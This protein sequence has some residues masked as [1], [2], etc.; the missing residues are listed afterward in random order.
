MTIGE[1]KPEIH[2]YLLL[3]CRLLLF[4]LKERGSI[5]NTRTA[6]PRVCL[7]R[8][9]PFPER[10]QNPWCTPCT[11]QGLQAGYNSSRELT[12]HHVSA[13]PSHYNK[14]T[15][16]L[17]TILHHCTEPHNWDTEVNRGQNTRAKLVA[18]VSSGSSKLLNVEPGDGSQGRGS[19]TD[20][21]CRHLDK[22][23]LD[24]SGHN[25]VCNPPCA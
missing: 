13:T 24:T 20:C 10:I 1:A 19:T 22:D 7:L 3:T 6:S 16:F 4:L 18:Q 11:L 21:T 12:I 8:Q 15:Y 25:K 5:V 17:S 14:S 9:R 23:W 2:S